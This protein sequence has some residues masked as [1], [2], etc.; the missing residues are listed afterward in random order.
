M[1]LIPAVSLK[2]GVSGI[3]TSPVPLSGLKLMISRPTTYRLMSICT[4]HPI[5][6]M[7]NFSGELL[8]EQPL[9]QKLCGSNS[10]NGRRGQIHDVLL[11]YAK[12][13]GV[14]LRFGQR[15]TDY[16][17]DV[18]YGRAGVIV[19]GERITADI[20]V[21]ADGVRSCARER[22]LVRTLCSQ[23]VMRN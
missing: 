7:H 9:P 3:S 14:D 6:Y 2:D 16:W 4:Q 21:G 1:H 22:V 11:R 19:E 12:R 17:E 5:M 20:V 13:I 8:A 15:V 23:E 10:Y 18:E